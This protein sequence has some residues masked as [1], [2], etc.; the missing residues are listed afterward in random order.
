LHAY[1]GASH[2]DYEDLDPGSDKWYLKQDDIAILR[3][4][5][6]VVKIKGVHSACSI[7]SESV[8]A[9]GIMDCTKLMKQNAIITIGS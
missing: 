8:V 9:I 6:S 2:G 3:Y 5:A 4:N 1:Q 7:I